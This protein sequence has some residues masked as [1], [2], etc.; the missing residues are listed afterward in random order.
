MPRLD[1]APYW[2][3]AWSVVIRS[4]VTCKSLHW[5]QILEILEVEWRRTAPS[6]PSAG[7]FLLAIM[8]W[9]HLS[10]NIRLR[11]ATRVWCSHF[12]RRAR[13]QPISGGPKHLLLTDCLIPLRLLLPSHFGALRAQSLGDSPTCLNQIVDLRASF[14]SEVFAD[15]RLYTKQNCDCCLSPPW[16]P[17]WRK[18][19]QRDPL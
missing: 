18:K 17:R 4:H 3:A 8:K 13:S 10:E 15:S 6:G 7:M 1:H 12:Y 16:Y 2:A 11:I 5:A 14:L 19:E 9:V